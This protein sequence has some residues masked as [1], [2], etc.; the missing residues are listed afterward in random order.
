MIVE[1]CIPLTHVHTHKHTHNQICRSTQLS[2]GFVCSC[3]CMVYWTVESGACICVPT[4]ASD[5][6]CD[7]RFPLFSVCYFLCPAP[8]DWMM[9]IMSSVSIGWLRSH[10]HPPPSPHRHF[11][12]MNVNICW[13]FVSRKTHTHTHLRRIYMNVY[14]MCRCVSHENTHPHTDGRNGWAPHQN[15]CNNPSLGRPYP[16]IRFHFSSRHWLCTHTD[17]SVIVPL[18]HIPLQRVYVCVFILHFHHIQNGFQYVLETMP[19]D[20]CVLLVYWTMDERCTV[21]S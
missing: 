2:I 18:P 6:V 19:E 20:I 4:L 10:I 15:D 11:N 16:G 3:I 5:R 9:G 13:L 21:T 14:S 17:D 7:T 12:R 8:F 1:F